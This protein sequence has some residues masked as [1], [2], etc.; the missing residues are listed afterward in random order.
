[1]AVSVRTAPFCL[2]RGD[3]RGVTKED[4]RAEEAGRASLAAPERNSTILQKR[5][6]NQT[7]VQGVRNGGGR[8]KGSSSREIDKLTIAR[9]LMEVSAE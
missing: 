9:Q 8:R 4:L 7:I 5:R 1:M 6:E 3:A 2:N